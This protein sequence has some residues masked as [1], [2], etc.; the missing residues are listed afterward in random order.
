MNDNK[1]ALA[2]LLTIRM[3]AKMTSEVNRSITYYCVLLFQRVGGKTDVDSR[4]H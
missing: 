4:D 2:S 1:Y 3:R